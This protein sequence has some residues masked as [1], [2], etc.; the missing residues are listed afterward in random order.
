MHVSCG[1][2]E[3]RRWEVFAFARRVRLLTFE[4]RMAFLGALAAFVESGRVERRK[5]RVIAREG[6]EKCMSLSLFGWY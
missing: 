1:M 6:S 3:T 2:A 4:R 5:R